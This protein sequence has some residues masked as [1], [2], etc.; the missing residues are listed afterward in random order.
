MEPSK[1]IKDVQRLAG[2]VAVLHRFISKSAEK[3]LP[4]F[5]ALREPKNF[6][7]TSECQQ[8]FDELK[9]YLASAPLLSK[10]VEGES[11]YLYLG[12][13]DE[14]VSSVLLRQQ[15]NHQKPVCYV[16]KVLQGAERNYPLAEKA[17]FALVYTARKLRAYFQS[18][19]IIIYT[20]LP[21]RK[22]LQKP[23]LS[24]RLIG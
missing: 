14:A 17:A 19:Q 9:Q 21:L 10:P 2:R 8:A 20:D 5:K 24:G 11:L 15:N 16:S 13:T 12:V 4:F 6:Q 23:E 3:C 22:I 7:W 18:H 1:T